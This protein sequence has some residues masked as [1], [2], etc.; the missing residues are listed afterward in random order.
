MDLWD[1]TFVRL[2]LL[3]GVAVVLTMDRRAVEDYSERY[4]AIG[5]SL[6]MTKGQFFVVTS[7][8]FVLSCRKSRKSAAQRIPSTK[9]IQHA[10]YFRSTS[11]RLAPAQNLL[12]ALVDLPDPSPLLLPPYLLLLLLHLSF[13]APHPIP[14]HQ[15]FLLNKSSRHLAPFPTGFLEEVPHSPSDC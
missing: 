1:S 2:P 12:Q 14:S 7:F 3:P 10:P 11:L 4:C 6:D 15:E 5:R 9:T 13:R 8:L